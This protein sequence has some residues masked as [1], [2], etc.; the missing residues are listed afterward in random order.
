MPSPRKVSVGQ[1]EDP[2]NFAA[3]F[4]LAPENVNELL[5]N[6]LPKQI[7]IKPKLCGIPSWETSVTTDAR[8]LKL[9]A[10]EI[11]SVR[12]DA[13]IKV[14][15]FEAISAHKS[16]WSC[17]ETCKRLGFISASQEPPI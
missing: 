13:E 12:P 8:W 16:H 2:D 9:V 7:V 5:P 1:L 11:R 15:E 3:G 4:R 17:G 14:V 6:A 10:N